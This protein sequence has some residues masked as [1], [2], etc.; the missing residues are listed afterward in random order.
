MAA[1]SSSSSSIQTRSKKVAM[2]STNVYLP[3]ECWK[4][5]FKF[6]INHDTEHS[7]RRYFHLKSLPLVSK[8]LLSI[9]NLLRSSL[10][11]YNPTCQFFHRFSNVASL[12]LSCYDGDLDDLLVQISCFP[13][14]ITSLNISNQLKIPTKGLRVFSK[15][16]TTLTSLVC[17]NIATL[18]YTHM[19][20]I[21]ECFPLLEE[22]DLSKPTRF[23]FDKTAFFPAQ[24]LSLALPELRQVNLS[25]NS[26]ISNELLF[27]LFKN[28]KL[29]EE[30]C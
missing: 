19:L 5:I 2:L 7:H 20:F 13:L 27:Y 4:Y 6:L 30:V 21:A 23:I 11:I 28:C 1:A 15:N 14:K 25:R 29:L 9:T 8:Q 17:S 24:A 18:Y 26:Y 12:D 3:D 22:L 10:T 16:I